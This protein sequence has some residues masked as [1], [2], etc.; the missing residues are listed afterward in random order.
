LSANKI[1][2]AAFK[3][4]VISCLKLSVTFEKKIILC[5][6]ANRSASCVTFIYTIDIFLKAYLTFRPD[7]F[8]LLFKNIYFYVCFINNP[9]TSEVAVA[10]SVF[11]CR[12]VTQ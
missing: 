10:T 12:P 8:F 6:A 7:F 4:K 3:A 2:V 11:G 9:W 1:I 5:L